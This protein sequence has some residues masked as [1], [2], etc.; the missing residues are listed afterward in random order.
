MTRFD[1]LSVPATLLAELANHGYHEA[2]PVQEAVL[3]PE[4][5]DVDLL[6]SSRTGSGKT[7]AF[8]LALAP[9][10]LGDASRLPRASK[11]L[12]LVVAP[13]RE[14][15]MQVER[16]LAWLY[17]GAGARVVTCVGGMDIRR[18]QRQLDDGAHIVVGTPGRLC[19]H[20]DRGSLDLSK[21]AAVVLDEADEMLDMGFRDDLERILDKAPDERRTLLFSATVPP[22]IEHLAKRYQKGAKRIV[23]TATDTAH[24]DITYEVHMVAPREREHAVVNIL[25]YHDVARAL[26]FCATRDTVARL[27]ASLEERGFQAVCLS[28]ELSQAERTRALHALRDGR[29]RVLVA[30]DVAAR[31]LDLPDV[32]LVIHGDLPQ[33]AAVMQHRSGRTGRAG[34]KGTAVVL[35]L[36]SQRRYAER[37]LDAARVRPQWTP[38]PSAEQI[39][40]LDGERLK[41]N[42][43]T[44]AES[45]EADDR[46]MAKALLETNDAESLIAAL[47]RT[48]RSALPAPEEMPQT[49]MEHQR[50]DRRAPVRGRPEPGFNR[51][52]DRGP[53]RG[54]DRG[55]DR[56]FDRPAPGAR[57][58]AQEGGGVWFAVNVGR[59]DNADPKW[60]I[61]MICR[62][63]HVTKSD[64]GKIVVLPHETR[65]EVNP[66]IARKFDEAAKA[67]DRKDPKI[68]FHV[69]DERG[70][71]R[72]DMHAD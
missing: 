62:R 27:Q 35:A 72:D 23:A 31:G 7:V 13:T 54:F 20:L 67:P 34:K 59:R 52:N 38:V 8:G 40:V 26:V 4:H 51:G 12:V 55:P 28:G 15:A 49:A 6:V 18:Q 11:P 22:P 42:I 50:S 66:K 45:V 61:P 68:R 3:S 24:Q 29:A 21:L 44:L 9:L 48:Q 10:L 41:Q 2:T 71:R 63:G 64:L 60:L 16:E 58:R 65:F 47:V 30:T 70:P 46:E 37:Q 53:Q 25:R 33:D 14:L 32:G 36:P 57:E 1:T 17:A 39:R 5:H 69:V 43:S 56:G 19:D